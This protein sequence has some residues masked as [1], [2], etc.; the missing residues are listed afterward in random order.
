MILKALKSA[1]EQLCTAS[2]IVFPSNVLKKF[3]LG[4]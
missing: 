3:A 1:T 2:Y 4:L